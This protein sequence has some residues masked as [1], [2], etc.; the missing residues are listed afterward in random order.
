MS[1]D[2]FGA[3]ERAVAILYQAAIVGRSGAVV[4]GELEVAPDPYAAQLVRGVSEHEAAL[5]A[6]VARFLRRDW[7]MD[8]LA[9]LDRIILRLAAYEL[10]HEPDVPTAVVIDQA[11]ELAKMFSTEQ[12]PPF[13]NG[14]LRS[15]AGQTRGARSV[16]TVSFSPSVRPTLSGTVGS[17][18]DDL[19]EVTSGGVVDP[20]IGLRLIAEGAVRVEAEPDESGSGDSDALLN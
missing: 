3:R 18:D 14:V 15:V 13:I 1:A 17:D 6:L 11:V 19:D 2:R 10:G 8:R 4:L 20:A 12:A 7:R 16:A 5:D 9:L